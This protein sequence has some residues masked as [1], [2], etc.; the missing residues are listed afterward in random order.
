VSLRFIAGLE[1]DAQDAMGD[2]LIL[3]FRTP[4]VTL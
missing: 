3:R 1:L 2:A 4:S